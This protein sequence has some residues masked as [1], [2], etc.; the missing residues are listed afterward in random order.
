MTDKP[1]VMRGRWRLR[2]RLPALVHMAFANVRA[3]KLRSFLT[4]LG[5]AIGT[6]SVFLLVSF[7]IGLQDLVATQVS[8]GQS[9]NT[10]DVTTA[11]SRT[12]QIDGSTVKDIATI[13]QVSAAGGYF[14]KA[15]K[16]T[17]GGATA[18][19][20]LYGVDELYLASGNFTLSAGKMIDLGK[21]NQIALSAS[22][23]EALGVTDAKQAVGKVVD[24][25]M[26][27]DDGTT[28]TEKYTVSGIV[29][30]GASTEAFVAPAIFTA[31]TPQGMAGIKVLADNRQAVTQ[32]RH[33]I[34]S[35]GYTTTSPLD[36]LN[37]I[38]QFF[39]IFRIVLVGFGAVGMLIAI[40]GM[41]NTLT[42]SLLERTK[43]VALMLALG[44]QARDMR[45]LFIVEAVILS[46]LG[47]IVGII[48]ARTVSGIVDV[49][50]NQLA[51]GRGAT[52]TF[53]VFAAPPW[54]ILVSLAIMAGVG[55]V[56][57]FLPARRAA[58]VNS[59]EALR[60]E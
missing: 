49:V 19:V 21:T 32:I 52:T 2:I 20:V 57:A 37:Q 25:S 45:Q 12:L 28:A 8:Q 53:T 34:E 13:P 17:I 7:G 40:L 60:R 29:S 48:G 3:K 43:E 46:L 1:P 56:V 15:S 24:V 31:G 58:R 9:I 30:S 47:G 36:T 18:D 54:L 39:R 35:R 16:L 59:I 33:S 4:M 44:A 22:I 42:V 5:I 10:I 6:G 26:R 14:A 11:G 23:L 27:R 55:Y 38:D 50:L 51:H 41:I